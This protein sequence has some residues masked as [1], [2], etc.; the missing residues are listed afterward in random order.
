MTH[1]SLSVFGALQVCVDG[2]PVKTFRSVKSRALLVY[3]AMESDRPHTRDAI[4]GLLWPEQ[5]N[6]TARD[7]LRQTLAILRKTIGDSDDAPSPLLEV[8]RSTIQFNPSSDYSVDAI[9]FS[10][11]LDACTRHRHRHSETCR[12]CAESRRQVVELYCGDFLDQFYLSDSAPFEEWALLKRER[13]REQALAALAQLVEFHTRHGDHKQSLSFAL[14]QLDLDPWREEAH[15][16]AMRA[17]ALDGRLSAA[18][19]QYENCRRG[20]ADEMGVEPAQETISL[21]EAI[22]EQAGGAPEQDHPSPLDF[23]S[24]PCSLPSPVTPLLGREAELAELDRLLSDPS[25]RLVSVAGPGGV[26][27][28]RLAIAAG[29][30]QTI[31]FNDGVF[32]VSLASV[33]SANLIAPTMLAALGVSLQ[34]GKD[35]EQQLMS[36][37]REREVLLVLDNLEHLLEGTQLLA[38]ILRRAPRVT[39]LVTSRERLNLQGEWVLD[40]HGLSIPEGQTVKEVERYSAVQLFLQSARRGRGASSFSDEEKSIIVRICR[41]VEGMPLAIELAA[42]WVRTLSCRDIADEIEKSFGF[43]TTALRDV[44]ERHRSISAVFEHS[45]KLLTAEERAA[46]R[47]LSV[48]QGGFQREAAEKVAGASL[49]LLAALMDKSLVRSTIPE[50]YDLHTLI[51]QF[52]YAELTE[53]KESEETRQRHAE[54]YLGVAEA[55]MMGLDGPDQAM[56]LQRLESENGNIR[57]SLAWTVEG[58]PERTE[59]ALRLCGALARTWDMRGYASEGRRWLR[60][61]LKLAEGSNGDVGG[62]PGAALVVDSIPAVVRIKALIAAGS[63]A[64]VQGDHLEASSFNQRA[65]ELCEKTGNKAAMGTCLLNLGTSANHLGEYAKGRAFH[66]QALAI[67]RE[68]GN[69]PGIART[70]LNMGFG[71]HNR[72]DLAL[73]RTFYEESLALRREIGDQYG[74]ALALGNLALL[75]RTEGDYT[76]ARALVEESLSLR[77]GIGDQFGI[78]H[79]FMTLAELAYAEHDNTRAADLYK[80]SLRLMQKVGDAEMIAMCLDM[81]AEV[82]VNLGEVEQGIALWGAADA[83]REA[84]STPVPAVLREHYE[85]T[86]ARVRTECGE[87]TFERAWEQGRTL[88]T[89]Q[90]I[91]CALAEGA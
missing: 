90:S 16:Q 25:C 22:K 45:W 61:A 47:R 1:L 91:A 74:T 57:S 29:A 88:S 44:P 32:F 26:G 35:T 28:T 82:V 67:Y 80:Q 5:P 73:A 7:N 51:R 60:Q 12:V 49:S 65:L 71:A 24:P 48:F 30:Q 75:S 3:L 89:E 64:S 17:L 23:P 36:Y 46:L 38:E 21:Y 13:L 20:L 9:K 27:K 10:S 43:L 86:I 34:R 77:R 66:E 62:A 8:T 37:L 84:L 78:A 69:K 19:A 53:A 79:C 14:R 50:W 81:L 85:T 40:L 59:T 68:L 56:W 87:D 52:A 39:M 72:G 54:Y 55:A 76:R 4:A 11:L 33:D 31:E 42:A 83:I 58:K 63:L 15:R 2:Q 41:M 6:Q 70:L 18:L